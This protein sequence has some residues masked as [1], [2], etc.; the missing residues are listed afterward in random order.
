MNLTSAP[1]PEL[2]AGS[3]GAGARA[4]H[5]RYATEFTRRTGSPPPWTGL[6]GTPPPYVCG[7]LN[8]GRWPEAAPGN[9]ALGLPGAELVEFGTGSLRL[10]HATGLS[11]DV[12]REL[13]LTGYRTVLPGPR[14]RARLT[15]AV[16]TLPDLSPWAAEVVGDFVG[17]VVLLAARPGQVP[18]GETNAS[19]SSCSFGRLPFT[20]FLTG[21]G[22]H[23][24]P[25][26]FMFTEPSVYSLQESLFHEALL[27]WLNEAHRIE[28][29]F[30]T[31]LSR[32]TQ[33]YVSWHN[34]WWS[35][36]RCLRE[37]FV[38]AHLPALRAVA[39]DWYRG[40]QR[41]LLG[42]ALRSADACGRELLRSLAV[43]R[44]LLS[45]SGQELLDSLALLL[46]GRRG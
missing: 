1:Q 14:T 19:W 10:R 8:H 33:V 31:E 5:E 27:L 29:A 23:R 9:E 2:A 40:P 34:T 26:G 25:P 16:D 18:A 21:L 22:L 24:L 20:V 39:L 32:A 28:D 4:V 15:E 41:A 38:F 30:V 46:P 3:P 37:L 43:R 11:P 13:G 36:G 35:A 12:L 44:E 17:A 42:D 45:P 7:R 6:P